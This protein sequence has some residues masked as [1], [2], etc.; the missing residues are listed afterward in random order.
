L[1]SKFIEIS[2]DYQYQWSSVS[3]KFVDNRDNHRP[4]FQTLR[5]TRLHRVVWGWRGRAPRISDCSFLTDSGAAGG[6]PSSLLRS[7]GCFSSQSI[8]FFSHIKLALVTSYQPDSSNFL[9]QQTIT[10]HQPQPVEQRDMWKA[11]LVFTACRVLAV[12]MRR[13][14]SSRSACPSTVVLSKRWNHLA[15]NYDQ[16][17]NCNSRIHILQNPIASYYY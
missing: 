17:Y 15:L 9:S 7:A 10:G 6:L 2:I 11:S 13:D 4:I 16:T 5:K 1:V 12:Q 8:V 14:G 3:V